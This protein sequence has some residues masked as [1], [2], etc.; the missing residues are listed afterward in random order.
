MKVIYNDSFLVKISMFMRIAGITLYPFIILRERYKR[1]KIILNHEMI[2]I[3]QQKELLVLFFY[4]FY[5]LEF[6]LKGFSYDKISFERE[7]VANKKD[8]NYLSKRKRYS[9]L[10]YIKN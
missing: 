1:D 4:I 2:H 5:I 9:F 6:I 10:K 3:E 8:L 7:A